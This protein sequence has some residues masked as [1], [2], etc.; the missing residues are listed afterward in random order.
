VVRLNKQDLNDIAGKAGQAFAR[1]VDAAFTATS[2]QASEI[3]AQF[4][5]AAQQLPQNKTPYIKT[6]ASTFNSK[7][8][9]IA[10]LLHRLPL[11]KHFAAIRTYSKAKADLVAAS[12]KIAALI[13]RH[14]ARQ[15]AAAPVTAKPRLSFPQSAL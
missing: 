3:L 1:T 14:A 2:P 12:P 5:R 4:Y 9:R 11:K 10:T 13:I 6:I 15:Q 7:S 8:R